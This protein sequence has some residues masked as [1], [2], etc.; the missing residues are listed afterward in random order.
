MGKAFCE[1]CREYVD[2]SLVTEKE[3]TEFEGMRYVYPVRY[4][5]CQRC[6]GR[7]TPDEVQAENQ[8]SFLDAVRT[9]NGIVSQ[10]TIEAIPERYNIGKRPLSKVLGWGEQSYS[11]FI[12]GDIPSREYS[13]TIS[14]IDRSPLA[15]LLI[16]HTNTRALTDLAFRKSKE[17]AM[18]ALT[19]T[20]SAAERAAAYILA[21]TGSSSPLGLQKELYYAN[22]LCEAFL[23]RPLVSERCEAWTRGPVYPRLWE[24][25]E[26]RSVRE[27]SMFG[28]EVAEAVGKTFSPEERE[29]LEAVISRI[30][31]YSPFAL[32][33]FTHRE[34]PWREA[35]TDVPDG[36]PSTNEISEES[37]RRFFH[38]LKERYRM[39]KPA[40]IGE[41]MQDMVK[42]L[43]GSRIP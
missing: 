22:G 39:Q 38:T 9:E 20:S 42:D 25:L 37:V 11:R 14:R 34:A 3:V 1:H 18:R 10:R 13:K 7:A 26:L 4:G 16:L 12:E 40:D 30:A 15:Y 8:R 28:Q 35:R 32:Q 5:V 43:Q 21:K 23:G 41:Y 19:S 36:E 29:V 24:T 2:V 17:A 27:E 6:G 33:D 31:C